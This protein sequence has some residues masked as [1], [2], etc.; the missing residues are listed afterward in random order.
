[1][2]SEAGKILPYL[3]Y[4][5]LASDKGKQVENPRTMRIGGIG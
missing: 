2:Y 1:M 4:N 3:L 5:G